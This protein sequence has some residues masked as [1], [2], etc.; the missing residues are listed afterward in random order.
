MRRI[1]LIAAAALIAVTAMPSPKAYAQLGGGRGGDADRQDQDAA[2]KKKRD[3][4]WGDNQAPLPA[5]RNAG[6]CPFVKTLYDAARYI[7][8][9]DDKVG[10]ADTGFTGEIQNISAGCA[11]KDAEP[12]KV[13]MEILF[14]L[15]RGPQAQGSSKTYRYWVAVTQRNK[16]VIAKKYFDLPVTFPAGQ[17]RVYA[18]DTIE[19]IV[20]PRA[21]LT[22]SGSNFEI[23]VGFDVTPE[24]AAFN[25]D[26]K[27]F[28]LNAGQAA[29]SAS[30][31]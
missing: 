13:R 3:E 19:E 7:E 18:T 4:E 26:G 28:R 8:F 24:M 11:Y 27:R 1:L 12:I 29:E 30:N 6:P 16:M 23:L 5:L 17:D 14:E 25:R 21:T 15:G 31:P 20:I 22:T 9:K 10:S 2:K